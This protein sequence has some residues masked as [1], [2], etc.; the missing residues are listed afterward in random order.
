METEQSL[1]LTPG[2]VVDVA[3]FPAVTPAKPVIANAIL[4][5]V[6]AGGQPQPVPLEGSLVLTPEHD[7]L[8]VQMQGQFLSTLRSPTQRIFVL[9][10]G[11]TVF[12]AALELDEPTAAGPLERI[13]PGSVVAVT[14]VYSYQWGPAPSFRLF[15]RSPADL[16]VLS[17]APWWTMRHTAVMIGM[18]ALVAVA[19][20][21]WVRTSGNRK[22]Q[23]YQAVLNERSRLGRELHDTL[24]QGLAGIGLQLEAV[25]GSM[26][27]APDTARQALDVAKQMLQYSQ[28]EAR[29]SVMDLRSQALESRDLAG[30]LTDVARQMT[31]GTRG[32]R[33][34]ARR[35]RAAP[36][37]RRR[38]T[39]S[40]AH[41][42]RSPDQCRQARRR[43]QRRYRAGLPA[44]GNRAHRAGRRVRVWRR[45]RTKAR[46]AT[47]ACWASANASTRLVVCWRSSGGPGAGTRLAVT[48]PAER[49]DV[50]DAVPSGLGESWTQLR[51]M[52]VDDHYL[53][54]MGL[55]SVLAL[56]PDMTICAEAANGEQ[57][58]ALFGKNGPTSRLMDL[59]LPGMNG[60]ATT[61]EIRTEFPDARIVMISTYVGDEEIYG[62][63]HAGAMGYL[64]KIGPA[65]RTDAAIRK[66]AAGQRHIPP[67]VAERL[68]DRVTRSELSARELDV[69]RLLVSGRRNREIA[70]ALA[71]TEGTVKLH[72]SSILGKLGAVDRTEA[73]TIALQRGIVQ[74]DSV[75]HPAGA[76]MPFDISPTTLQLV[77]GF[78]GQA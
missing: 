67:E 18:L 30:A 55:R 42:A 7:A 22:R 64:V 21:S 38:G 58:R 41:R 15:L 2:M 45:I 19:G 44:G 23:E 53:V 33:R 35:R 1:K 60:A 46:A 57:A 51:I 69:L 54:R 78:P 76:Y 73:V 11:E 74:L 70:N 47:S 34:G 12:D 56:E 40:A 26:H 24:E 71:I 8:L 37:R 50:R 43:A 48:I 49:R 59:R 10:V 36:A 61:Q 65:R 17:A 29:R 77:D 4:R 9:Q 25:A 20:G 68:A 63:L 66:A 16:T 52:L 6:G 5:V 75:V 28:E 27:T 13:Q 62:A 3:G 14:G 32:A 39:P 72:V 31:L